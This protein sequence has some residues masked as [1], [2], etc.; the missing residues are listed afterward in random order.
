[1][2]TER[3]FRLLDE[4]GYHVLKKGNIYLE[5]FNSGYCIVLELVSS[6]PE[7]WEEVKEDQPTLESLT[8]QIYELA[9]KQGMKCDVVL[10]KKKE[11]EVDDFCAIHS[12][13]TNSISISVRVRNDV[14][15][16]VGSKQYQIIKAIKTILEND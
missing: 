16:N 8:T 15:A 13:M 9:K 12:N 3:K 7:D 2:K 10:E 1:M 14:L 5:S 11:V 6:Y 4:T